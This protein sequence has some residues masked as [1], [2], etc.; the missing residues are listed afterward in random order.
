MTTADAER[1][2]AIC[3]THAR[4]LPS[5]CTPQVC[6]QPVLCNLLPLATR[7]SWSVH[8]SLHSQPHS[9]GAP[10][11]PYQGRAGFE[12][13]HPYPITLI[14]CRHAPMAPCSSQ[15]NTSLYAPLTPSFLLMYTLPMCS[16]DEE[17]TRKAIAPPP[18]WKAPIENGS[19]ASGMNRGLFLA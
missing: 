10:A 4:S 11:C 8:S 2:L 19:H 12:G 6:C 14:P 3:L 17:E 1:T 9:G 15:T 18:G 13:Q 5:V 16:S 7:G